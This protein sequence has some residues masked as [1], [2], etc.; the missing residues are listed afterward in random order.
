MLVCACGEHGLQGREGWRHT[1]EHGLV[2]LPRQ[3]VDDLLATSVVDKCAGVRVGETTHVSETIV[4]ETIGVRQRHRGPKPTAQEAAQEAAQDA[5]QGEDRRK[6]GRSIKDEK[7]R[8]VKDVVDARAA[9]V[10]WYGLEHDGIQQLC[11]PSLRQ[12][13]LTLCL[14][15]SHP[16]VAHG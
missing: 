12:R 6:L 11:V 5:A 9:P 14:N 16:P 10:D 4:S 7:G 8:R 15:A 2:Q 3:P 13:Q 1:W